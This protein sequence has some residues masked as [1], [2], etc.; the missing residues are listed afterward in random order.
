MN[1]LYYDSV[2]ITIAN[3]TLILQ[4]PPYRRTP[5]NLD[6]AV[7][8]ENTN[9]GGKNAKKKWPAFNKNT[10]HFINF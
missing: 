5:P 9:N 2:C 3:K 10:S 6:S 8:G 4:L 7:V 1:I